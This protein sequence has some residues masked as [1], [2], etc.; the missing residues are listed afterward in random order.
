MIYDF[1]YK[2]NLHTMNIG[3]L[4]FFEIDEVKLVVAVMKVIEFSDLVS[5]EKVLRLLVPKISTS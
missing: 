1:L 4:Q 3:G 2:N 5:L